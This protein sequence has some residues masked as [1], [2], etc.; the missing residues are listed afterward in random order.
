MLGGLVSTNG[1]VDAMGNPSPSIVGTTV[2]IYNVGAMIGCVGAALWGEKLARRGAIF[3]GCV[4]V[5]IG[6]AIQASSFG[7]AQLIVARIITVTMTQLLS[8]LRI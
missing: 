5:V 4:I 3:T 6:A 7:I 2:A 8:Q 1:F